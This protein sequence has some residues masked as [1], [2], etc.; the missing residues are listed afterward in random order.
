MRV[1][2]AVA[3][4][5]L[6]CACGSSP[7]P[8][9]AP[10]PVASAAAV[11]TVPSGSSIRYVAIDPNALEPFVKADLPTAKRWATDGAHAAEVLPTFRH[12]LVKVTLNDPASDAAARKKV[13]ALIA[14]IAKGESLASLA[15][16]SDDP[17]SAKKGGAYP[18]KTTRDFVPE[19]R[20]AYDDLRPG[21]FTHE[22]VKSAFG[23]HVIA[24][25]A[26]DDES[27]LAGYVHASAV[28]VARSVAKDLHTRLR[29]VGT[30]GVRGALREAFESVLKKS[31]AVLPEVSRLPKDAELS[32]LAFCRNLDAMA[33]SGKL[34]ES[35]DIAVAT[36]TDDPVDPNEIEG[37]LCAARWVES[38]RANMAKKADE[39]QAMNVGSWVAT[40]SRPSRLFEIVHV[41]DS[42]DVGV[43][44]GSQLPPNAELRFEAAPTGRA[45]ETVR[46][47]F[48]E[49][50]MAPGDK[51]EAVLSRARTWLTTVR[52]PPDTFFLLASIS[53]DAF[54][55]RGYRTYLGR[56]PIVDERDVARATLQMRDGD[57]M[58]HVSFRPDA[59]KR[60][61]KATG[62][63]RSSSMVSS[64]SRRS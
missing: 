22:P 41:D 1:V 53:D 8:A 2:A 56:D 15:I 63:S 59:A 4:A 19:V 5:S 36:L 48:V 61:A 52:H 47:D 60:L 7:P 39:V 40:P 21:T 44:I 33:R 43:T 24:K 50:T 11:A 3:F 27:T 13:E 30:D 32:P 6:T 29:H 58:V 28:E 9:D 64:W 57:A 45:Q 26:L 34:N 20:K 55:E 51:S 62:A 12:I 35:E 18:G 37:G 23:W 17:G 10:R 54:S 42:V 31:P 49:L 38:I 46:R 14:R 25:D 16:E